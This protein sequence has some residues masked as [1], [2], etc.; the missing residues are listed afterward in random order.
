MEKQKWTLEFLKNL[1]K[2]DIKNNLVPDINEN[3]TDVESIEN[4]NTA[5]SNNSIKESLDSDSNSQ[6]EK[7]VYVYNL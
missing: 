4:Q 7:K 2:K 5:L 1:I 3:Y 6:E